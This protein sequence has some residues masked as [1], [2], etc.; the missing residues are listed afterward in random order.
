MCEVFPEPLAHL[1]AVRL[2]GRSTS[3]R[4]L[5]CQSYRGSPS[6]LEANTGRRVMSSSGGF[7]LL[8][9]FIGRP[10]TSDGPVMPPDPSKRAVGHPGAIGGHSCVLV[11]LACVGCASSEGEVPTG[12]GV[13]P[14][15]EGWLLKSVSGFERGGLLHDAAA[16]GSPGCIPLRF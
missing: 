11:V 6:T 15:G 10:D 9:S 3:L 7:N 16:G 14:E 4:T 8:E 2:L 13:S 1:A 12:G 5:L